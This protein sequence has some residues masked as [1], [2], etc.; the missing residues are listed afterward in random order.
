MVVECQEI[1]K[2]NNSWS[3][4]NVHLFVYFVS[5]Q[6]FFQKIILPLPFH[7]WL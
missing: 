4:S 7:A 3:N 2:F 1:Y 6:F 5:L